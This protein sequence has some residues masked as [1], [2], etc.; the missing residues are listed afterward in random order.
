MF[1]EWNVD[2]WILVVCF[3]LTFNWNSEGDILTVVCPDGGKGYDE[4]E[5]IFKI[6]GKQL[7]LYQFDSVTDPK[8]LVVI[9][10]RH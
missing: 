7:Y 5:Y 2:Y 1:L 9:L 4:D 10:T 6:S 8:E 3:T